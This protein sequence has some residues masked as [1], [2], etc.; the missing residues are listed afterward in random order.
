MI[1]EMGVEDYPKILALW[2]AAGLSW[3]PEGRD[4]LDRIREQIES[5][6]TFF[7]GE[8][9]NGELIGVVL[10][11]HDTR[12]GWLNRLA[13]LPQYRNRGIAQQLIKEA[14]DRLYQVN[15]IE[16]FCTLI[17]DDNE[18]SVSLFEK[19]GYESWTG[20]RYYSKRKRPDA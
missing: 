10:I 6:N 7:L 18:A 12:K 20:I 9:E 4:H 8:I 15:G 11:T 3:R 17:F 1:K 2:E 13:V 14:E 16:V 19:V 5:K